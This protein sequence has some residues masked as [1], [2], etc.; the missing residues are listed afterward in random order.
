MSDIF[1]FGRYQIIRKI[2]IGGM[3]EIFLA[4]QRGVAGFDRFAILKSLLPELA[5]E[6]ASLA[7]FLD[8][9]RVAAHLN[10][11]NVV[12]IYEVDQ[13]EGIY[14]IAMEYIAGIDL[15]RM[16]K[17]ARAQD[18]ALPPAIVAAVFRDACRGLGYAHAAVDAR[19][20]PLH[21]VHRD[22]TPHNIMVRRDGTAKVVDF[23]IAKAA[24]RSVR[25][26]TGVLKGKLPYMAPEQVRSEG[27]TA[28]SDQWSLGA[29]FWEMLTG[30]R[31]ITASE[32]MD[33]LRLH[34]VGGFPPPS[35]L[36]ASV[37]PVL[38]AIA[39]RMIAADPASRFATCT[40]VAEQL[41]D[42]VR[43]AGIK[44]ADVADFVGTVAGTLIEAV[45]A[46][47]TPQRVNIPK[48][49]SYAS[50]GPVT[51][52]GT[53]DV[54]TSPWQAVT[55]SGP[56][57][58]AS[59]DAAALGRDRGEQGAHDAKTGTARA[60]FC[61]QC[62]TPLVAGARF[63]M[64]CGAPVPMMPA[65]SSPATVATVATV[66]TA[67]AG[68]PGVQMTSPSF[69]ARAQVSTLPGSALTA[70]FTTKT[71]TPSA[72]KTPVTGD[73]GQL[74]LAAADEL[75]RAVAAEKRTV[76]VVRAS[77]TGVLAPAEQPELALE[78]AQILASS[79]ADTIRAAGGLV[80]NSAVDAV[81]FSV[82][83]EHTGA[84]DPQKAI[85]I[86]VA[87]SESTRA[88]ATSWS[89]SI[90]LRAAIDCGPAIVSQTSTGR[91]VS[92]A[93]KDRA[94]RIER[95]VGAARILVSVEVARLARRSWETAAP[96]TVKD[97]DL[98]L[99]VAAV[100]GP[101]R[102]VTRGAIFVGRERELADART[103]LQARPCQVMLVGEAGTGRTALL[104]A[105]LRSENNGDVAVL[106]VLA[107]P[108]ASPY[109][110]ARALVVGDGDDAALRLDGLAL[111]GP[112]RERLRRVFF[113]QGEPP[114]AKEAAEAM[115]LDE[116]AVVDALELLAGANTTG[117]FLVVDDWG[118]LDAASRAALARVGSKAASIALLATASPSDA[119]PES[120]TRIA[121]RPLDATSIKA[122]VAHELG[123]DDVPAT[124]ATYVTGHAQ[125]NPSLA[126]LLVEDLVHQQLVT[127]YSGRVSLS[128]ALG[129]TPP[130]TSLSRVY[131]ARFDRLT[132]E[133]RGLLRA[134]AV[135]GDDFDVEMA[136]AM[137]GI[138]GQLRAEALLGPALQ[139]GLLE[140][141][142]ETKYGFRPGLRAA[143]LARTLA[144]DL[145][146]L[147]RRA[148]ELW[149]QRATND[150]VAAL[151]AMA[152]HAEAARDERRFVV[153]G[154]R[155]ACALE[156]RGARQEALAWW[157]K[158]LD[159]AE[160]L[161]RQTTTREDAV[162]VVQY[163]TDALT[164][165]L[166]LD[167]VAVT[168]MFQRYAESFL[169]AVP[170]ETQAWALYAYGR[171][172]VAAGRA[173]E[174]VDVFDRALELVAVDDEDTRALFLSELGGALEA[175]GEVAGAV[176]QIVE[177]FRRMQ[178]RT[179]RH[180]E[181]AFEA[182]NR[183]GRLYLRSKATAKA[184]DTFRMAMAQAS[185]IDDESGVSRSEMNL[186]T[187]AALEGDPALAAQ[188][189]GAAATRAARAG[190]AV[191]ATRARLNLGRLLVSTTPV[192]AKEILTQALAASERL[193]W[194]EGV[195]LCRQALAAVRN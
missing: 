122:V 18:V 61:A 193:G 98:S 120:A 35:S 10:H 100:T 119:L 84:D 15:S 38:D 162:V 128:P 32:P 110:M 74:G 77:V 17:M 78:R 66:A 41:D 96:F 21:L 14:Y 4:R 88:F 9:A 55:R 175:T 138:D 86:A 116:L 133:S 158:S 30:R 92:G 2:A 114:R 56:S 109:A 135:L 169:S 112:T 167:A 90:G 26:S 161:A 186:G 23:G 12:A 180:A 183:L 147:H 89:V 95:R 87:L 177:A 185:A 121:L 67:T 141:V 37:P 188:L 11:P 113:G 63:C 58:A 59:H 64:G 69:A 155:A 166:A 93:P 73:V 49:F 136:G 45:T 184:R 159:V 33:I 75:V 54:P 149:E 105:L 191:Q 143:V 19:G 7:A 44:Q 81:L 51:S 171:A 40:E 52:A 179:N 117:G 189:F 140:T 187:C 118:R 91:R 153:C 85:A 82:G 129:A 130:P 8:E 142:Q 97:D 173:K 106:R 156:K 152:R 192:Q 94:Q 60:R 176:V 165:G 178:G 170:Q 107:R 50:P 99:E 148:L 127:V 68:L 168:E 101:A 139:V 47:T 172:L 160:R 5:Q 31:L 150:D 154:G 157:R 34:L 36:V 123:I 181:F 3:G 28:R 6:E 53:D 65:S 108:G 27:V 43:G 115:M 111:P 1:V 125:G 46:D 22:A 124:L 137:I 131:E 48:A 145:L 70:Q 79:F 146:V 29:S 190:D 62:A 102:A 194:K 57:P 151:E 42:F 182:L 195:A 126:R 25:T 174:A 163:A 80:E 164:T 71:S 13:W 24:N 16:A 104:D 83:A 144:N 72:T 20:A 39:S 132:D 76:C 103:A 134:A